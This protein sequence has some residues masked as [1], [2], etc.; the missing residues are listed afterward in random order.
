MIS[1]KL[2]GSFGSKGSSVLITDLK[3]SFFPTQIAGPDKLH[4]AAIGVFLWFQ[5]KLE[6]YWQTE[7]EKLRHISSVCFIPRS[8]S[9][10][11]Y[12]QNLYFH[13]Y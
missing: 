1:G 13:F 8:E 6:Q 12:N 7:Y 2:Q 5:I 10:T 4:T 11:S 3:A 9:G